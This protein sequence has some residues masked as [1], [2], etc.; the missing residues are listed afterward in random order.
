[1]RAVVKTIPSDKQWCKIGAY[2]GARAGVTHG[3]LRGRLRLTVQSRQGRQLEQDTS[4]GTH[5]QRDHLYRNVRLQ[6]KPL[7]YTS[8]CQS[9]SATSYD[10]VPAIRHACLTCP[11]PGGRA[12]SKQPNTL[13]PV[14]FL[15]SPLAKVVRTVTA[16]VRIGLAARLLDNMSTSLTIGQRHTQ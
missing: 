3:S 15:N 6:L 2:M 8:P 10:A 1:M 16:L 13:T 14:A 11:C 5:E 7:N 12:T 4:G 9:Q